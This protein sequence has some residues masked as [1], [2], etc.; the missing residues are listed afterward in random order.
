M[1]EGKRREHGRKAMERV[2]GY[3]WSRCLDQLEEALRGEAMGAMANL[4]RALQGGG[5]NAGMPMVAGGDNRR[6][7]NVGDVDGA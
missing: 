5:A 7:L 4:V 3:T 2:R 1:D 6:N